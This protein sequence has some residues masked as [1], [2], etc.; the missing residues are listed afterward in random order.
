MHLSETFR[1]FYCKSGEGLKSLGLQLRLTVVLGFLHSLCIL[2]EFIV[3]ISGVYISETFQVFLLLVRRWS[4]LFGVSAQADSGFRILA[5]LIY[6]T[7]SNCAYLWCSPLW[8]FQVF[9]LLVRRESELFGVSA[10]TDSGIRISAFFICPIISY[11]AYFWFVSLWAFQVSV[12][13]VRR[14]S[15]LLESQLRLTVVLG[16]C[17]SL[18]TVL[19]VIFPISCF[20]SLWAFQVSVFLVRR[21]S[22]LI[23]VWAQTDSGIRISAFLIYPIRSY[24]AYFWCAP[25]LRLS[26]ICTLSQEERVWTLWS[27][28]SDWQWYRI[29]FLHSLY[30]LS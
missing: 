27:V 8:D 6:P 11:F 28:S 7:R 17:H 20:V 3:P 18:H 5:S 15:E 4:E 22:E 12:L 9:Q 23:G 26:G 19:A 1:Y 29:G 10:Q 16:F 25:S 21:G 30:A 13:L 2:P 24:C 14:G